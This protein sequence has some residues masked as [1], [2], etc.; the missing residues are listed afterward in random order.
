MHE[1]FSP[2]SRS[3][4]VHLL[5]FPK[6]EVRPD[7]EFLMAEWEKLGSVR[8]V[9][10]KSLEEFRQKGIIGNSLEA[11]VLIHARGE[12]LGL[13]QRHRADLRYIFI[14]SCVDVVEAPNAKDEMR[15]DVVKADGWKCE[16][17]WNYSTAVGS[18]ATYPT[19]CKR[20]VPAVMEMTSYV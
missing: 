14:V 2:E 8:E 10:L 13:L 6:H 20:C 17:C 12:T 4:S 19:L 11:K 16:R 9:V 3:E 1:G 18:D 7:A 15:I 5:R